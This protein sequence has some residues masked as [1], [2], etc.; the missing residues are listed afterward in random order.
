MSS[1]IKIIQ[2]NLKLLIRSKAS[3]L[4][5]ILGPLLLIF[6]A[7]IAFD[8]SNTYN[9]D[10]GVFSKDYSNVTNSLISKLS[11]N[12]FVINKFNDEPD[13]IENI[14]QG[15][16]DACIVFP[17]NMSFETGKKNEIIFH[18]DYSKMNLVYV[19]LDIITSTVYATETEV[20][21]DLTAVLLEKLEFT[22]TQ[23]NEKRATIS[24]IKLDL[25]SLKSNTEGIK[26]D[27]ED[28]DLSIS[29]D[30]FKVNEIKDK[31][32]EVKDG[33]YSFRTDTETRLGEINESMSQLKIRIDKLNL[34][35]NSTINH[36][37]SPINSMEANLG[38]IKFKLGTII[39]T[40]DTNYESMNSLISGF[41]DNLDTLELNLNRATNTKSN[42]ISILNSMIQALDQSLNN[43]NIIES[44]FN[45]IE[46]NI[47]Q[48]RV[49]SAEEIAKPITTTIKP[50]TSERTQLNYLFPSLM[51]LV[52]MFISILLSTTIIMM[53]K[54]SPAYFRNFITP[55]KD[56]I[57]ILANYLTSILIVMT[58]T[59]IILIVSSL[60]FKTQIFANI[61]MIIFALMIIT[62][63][64][65][66]VGLIIG[67]LFNSEETA[68]LG[69]IS[70][71]TIFLLLS[72]MILPLES[73]PRYVFELA[74]FNPF[75]ISE[76]LLRRIILFN[77]EIG[78]LTTEIYTLLIYSAVIFFF[79]WISQK[80][81][82][83]HYLHK[84]AYLEHKLMLKKRAKEK[85][86]KK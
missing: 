56:I 20:S 53:E 12:E 10:L 45:D 86:K 36:L 29:K 85:K 83:S 35:S 30:I 5:V 59:V 54:H 9:I 64:F 33:V 41:A 8:T 18:I 7:G 55:T 23:I 81:Y 60:F 42:T 25:E 39:G 52:I 34:T 15:R 82:K 37:M 74:R 6:L 58:Q 75:V 48:I 4:I 14:K 47:A 84:L 57:F 65:T 2:K 69:S 73:M 11:E 22:K 21:R 76:S 32:T 28:M 63:F 62:S 16:I 67:Y 78:Q 40:A 50:V 13:C 27:L 26:S 72:N 31:N 38:G 77:A 61:W 19:I 46:Q 24:S 51:V 80:I 79:I 68:T 1:I 49:T 3:A 43:I 44:M 71:G 70:I 66:L 17:Q